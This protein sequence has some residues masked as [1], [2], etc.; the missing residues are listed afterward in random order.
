MKSLLTASSNDERSPWPKS[1]TKVTSA[2]PIIRA[3]AVDAVRAGFRVALSRARIPDAPPIDR[4]G[5]PST[6]AR[7]RTIFA[8]FIETPKKRSS[9][10][11]PIA[12]SRGAVA[13]LLARE[14]KQRSAIASSSTINE[15]TGPYFAQRET[16]ITEP[17]RTA[18]IG[19]TRVARRAGRKLA[20]SVIDVPTRSETTIVRVAK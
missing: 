5:A 14:P 19:G 2:R 6:A 20:I 17:S 18:A 16:G 1:A 3:D 11:I 4:A 9:T 8:A 13:A 15:V 10:P 7:G 12:N